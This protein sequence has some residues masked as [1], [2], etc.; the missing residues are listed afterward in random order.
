MGVTPLSRAQLRSGYLSSTGAEWV[1]Y[2]MTMPPSI[3]MSWPVM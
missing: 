1:G 3:M 2:W